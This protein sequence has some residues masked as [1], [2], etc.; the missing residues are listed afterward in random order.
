MHRA[1][2][3]SFLYK[4]VHKLHHEY[5]QPNCWAV[6]YAHPLEYSL[7]NAFG[8]FIGPALLDSHIYLFWT[9][10]VIRLL[11]GIDGHCGYD[12]WF[13]PFRY[14]PFRPGANVHDYHHSHNIGNYG[15]FFTFW[16]TVCGTNMN[17][18]DYKK[19]KALKET[20]QR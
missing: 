4:H 8:V 12:F 3:T 15:S 9:W 19:R 11:E 13:S 20:D 6:E 7:V 14:F 10:N 17:Y 16:D 1:L 18:E 2:H 5:K